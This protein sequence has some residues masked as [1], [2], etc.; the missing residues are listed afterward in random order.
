MT[1]SFKGF[2][3]ERM[4]N[5][6]ENSLSHTLKGSEKGALNGLAALNVSVA[7]FPPT[8]SLG[9]LEFLSPIQG[10][11]HITTSLGFCFLSVPKYHSLIS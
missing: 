7:I 4:N 10:K 8:V 11:T 6:L 2:S 9:R 5:C 1:Q 3:H